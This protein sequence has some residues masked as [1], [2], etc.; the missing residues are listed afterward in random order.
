MATIQDHTDKCS[1]YL[2]YF[3]DQ[4]SVDSYWNNT[5]WHFQYSIGEKCSNGAAAVVF[6]QFVCNMTAGNYAAVNAR[7]SPPCNYELTMQSALAC[8]VQSTQSVMD[9]PTCPDGSVCFWTGHEYTGDRRV[10]G[11]T[12]AG[13]HQ[14]DI[15]AK[16][17]KNRFANRKVLM[18]QNAFQID[19]DCVGPGKN[20]EAFLTYWREYNVGQQESRC[21]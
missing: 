13:W 5:Q 16:S 1:H 8:Q 10:K 14:I 3:D 4:F 12:D 21:G 15:D 20:E 11:N 18:R 17:A 7:F 9:V 19:P 6:L 2:A